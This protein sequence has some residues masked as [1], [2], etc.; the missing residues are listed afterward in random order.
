MI[1]KIKVDNTTWCYLEGMEI[2]VQEILWKNLHDNTVQWFFDKSEDDEN[3]KIKYINIIDSKN[4]KVIAT[5]KVC[6]LL[7]ENG[8][9]IERIN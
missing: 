6:F 7:N 9:T 8:K 5:N 3:E 2:Y 1:L 4:G